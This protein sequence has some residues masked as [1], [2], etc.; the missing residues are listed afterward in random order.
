MTAGATRP[1]WSGRRDSAAMKTWEAEWS[2]DTHLVRSD[3][4]I[5][6]FDFPSADGVHYI[7][8]AYSGLPPKRILF[9]MNIVKL[10]GGP[11]FVSMDGDPPKVSLYFTN[12]DWYSNDGRWWSNP[13]HLD[14]VPGKQSIAVAVTPAYWSNVNG[15]AGHEREHQFLSCSK[16]VQRVGF[17]FGGK[18]L[19]HGAYVTGGQA[20]CTFKH[21][22][23]A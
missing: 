3:E 19:G 2:K 4:G 17:T 23:I 10:S 14:L 8:R 20:R 16:N 12:G 9:E 1:S 6:H 11:A 21:K 15:K 7:T 13:A 22:V 18:F 5:W